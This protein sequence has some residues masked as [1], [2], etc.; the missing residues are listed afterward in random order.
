MGWLPNVNRH[1]QVIDGDKIQPAVITAVADENN[2][3]S[4]VD[5]RVGHLG[6]TYTGIARRTDPNENLAAVKYIPM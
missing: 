4:T 6:A 5:A 1:I 3:N 2:P